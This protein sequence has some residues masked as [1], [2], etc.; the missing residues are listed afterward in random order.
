MLIYSMHAMK[1]LLYQ[2]KQSTT[3]HCIRKICNIE[4]CV[5]LT[6]KPISIMGDMKLMKPLPFYFIITMVI[7]ILGPRRLRSPAIIK[8]MRA[9]VRHGKHKTIKEKELNQSKITTNNMYVKR[10]EEIKLQIVDDPYWHLIPLVRADEIQKE[11]K[12]PFLCFNCII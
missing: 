9:H 4:R 8:G 10:V 3:H 12:S 1:N 7:A 2:P 5:V 6:R 11:P